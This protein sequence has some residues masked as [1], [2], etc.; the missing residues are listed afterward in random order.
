MKVK[1]IIENGETDMIL[2]PENVFERDLL[3]KMHGNKNFDFR[4]IVDA[5]YDMGG[6][7]NHKITINIKETK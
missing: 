6:Y 7:S 5:K 1:V 4:T 2:T 3:K